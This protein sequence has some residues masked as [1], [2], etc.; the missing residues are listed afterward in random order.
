LWLIVAR[1]KS[2]RGKKDYQNCA[3]KNQIF[4]VLLSFLL[5]TKGEE[6]KN[7]ISNNAY[8]RKRPFKLL[9]K[10]ASNDHTSKNYRSRFSANIGQ[11]Q[12]LW[13]R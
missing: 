5:E 7:K 4:H 10:K 11:R 13:F 1:Q 3:D 9:C 12:K 8:P 2:N 6:D